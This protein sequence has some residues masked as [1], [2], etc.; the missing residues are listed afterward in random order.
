MVNILLWS[1]SPVGITMSFILL[2]CKIVCYTVA[3][4]GNS[5]FASAINL[6]TRI[7]IITNGVN[8]NKLQ[9][10]EKSYSRI[11]IGSKNCTMKNFNL[12]KRRYPALRF[13]AGHG[14]V[15]SQT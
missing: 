9:S 4:S 14:W 11:I 12:K 15:R 2:L 7:I 10:K 3:L 8:K 6:E 13:Y 1:L 5:P